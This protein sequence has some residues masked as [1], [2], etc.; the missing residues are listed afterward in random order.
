M[1]GRARRRR[2]PVRRKIRAV[3]CLLG[4]AEACDLG[5][6]GTLRGSTLLLGTLAVL[7]VTVVALLGVLT[8]LAAP[9]SWRGM[10]AGRDTNTQIRN[11]AGPHVVTSRVPRPEHASATRRRS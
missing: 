6:W 2:S 7:A 10:L 4:G 9:W 11:N 1:T 8:F 3:A 5:M